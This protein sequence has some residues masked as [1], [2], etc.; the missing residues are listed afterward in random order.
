MRGAITVPSIRHLGVQRN[1]FAFFTYHLIFFIRFTSDASCIVSPPPPLKC[2]TN[3]H[4]STQYTKRLSNFRISRTQWPLAIIT[5]K[6][7]QSKSF[8][9]YAYFILEFTSF[10]LVLFYR[11]WMQSLAS[12]DGAVCN[13]CR[14]NAGKWRGIL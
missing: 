3:F 9:Q 13:T 2:Q 14:H 8:Y 4:L 7:A 10:S 11:N 12:S 1:N 5:N 6:F